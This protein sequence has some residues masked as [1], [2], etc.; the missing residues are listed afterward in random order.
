MANTSD[1]KLGNDELARSCGTNTGNVYNIHLNKLLPF[2]PFGKPKSTKRG[3]QKSCYIN[4]S[5]CKPSISTTI[6]TRNYVKVHLSKNSSIN[7]LAKIKHGTTLQV[8]VK[9][10]NPDTMNILSTKDSNLN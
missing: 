6:S 4:N 9:N 2:I 8:S 7:P 10:K 5:K 1:W 3:L